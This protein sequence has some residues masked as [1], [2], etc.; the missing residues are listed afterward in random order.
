MFI[1]DVAAEEL[2][3]MMSGLLFSSP[4][5]Q[6]LPNNYVQREREHEIE[7]LLS[8]RSTGFLFLIQILRQD[9]Q[10]WRLHHT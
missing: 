6:N 9:K 10:G 8:R 4:A 2:I 3:P 7:G 5:H 1:Q